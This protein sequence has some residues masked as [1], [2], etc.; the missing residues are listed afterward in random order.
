MADYQWA[1]SS[2]EA[3]AGVVFTL[4]CVFEFMYLI[5]LEQACVQRQQVGLHWTPQ[6]ATELQTKGTLF[7]YESTC[8]TS[9]FGFRVQQ[10]I[11]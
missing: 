2:S 5:V 4:L 3:V 11:N 9:P 6:D 8:S 1:S 10:H 7:L